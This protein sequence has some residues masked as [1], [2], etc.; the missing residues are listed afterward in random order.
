MLCTLYKYSRRIYSFTEFFNNADFSKFVSYFFRL[1][2]C[3]SLKNHS[4]I[5][6]FL[7]SFFFNSSYLGLER[8]KIFCAVFG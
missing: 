6:K 8:K 1:F 4:E 5:R 7:K 2:L 3:L